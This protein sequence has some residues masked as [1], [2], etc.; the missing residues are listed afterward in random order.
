MLV[1]FKWTSKTMSVK[2]ILTGALCVIKVYFSHRRR[3][4]QH[5]N[6][7]CKASTANIVGKEGLENEAWGDMGKSAYH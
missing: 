7:T 1:A 2:S 3:V 4:L 5:L 6:V